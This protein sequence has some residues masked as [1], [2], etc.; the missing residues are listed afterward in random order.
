MHFMH[1]GDILHNCVVPRRPTSDPT[2]LYSAR[3]AKLSRSAAWVKTCIEIWTLVSD[4]TLDLQGFQRI[5]V[6]IAVP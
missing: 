6:A 2:R 3:Q 1:E 4:Y 5:K